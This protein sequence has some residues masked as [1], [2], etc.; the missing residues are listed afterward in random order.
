MLEIRILEANLC[1]NFYQQGLLI[2]LL[3]LCTR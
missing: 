1:Q 3:N 2:Q